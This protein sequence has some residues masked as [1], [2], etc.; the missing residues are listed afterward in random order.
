[1]R[2]YLD[3]SALVKLVVSERE[4]AALHAYL[5]RVGDDTLFTAAL[6]RTELVRAVLGA[7]IAA[8]AQARRILDEL[9]TVNLTRGLLDAA[10]DLR[11]ARLRTLDAIHLAAAR[12]AG[13]ELRAVVTYDNRMA[14]AAADLGI[15]VEAPV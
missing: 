8:V 6:T 3:T 14:G 9:D 12:R 11:P 5:R 10:A 15:P 13:A 2:A 7:G 4:S 1:M